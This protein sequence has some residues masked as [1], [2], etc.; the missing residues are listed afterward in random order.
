MRGR[1]LFDALLTAL[2]VFEMLYQITGNAL[3]EIVGAAFLACI[4]AHIAFAF[5]WLKNSVRSL[6][7]GKLAK[8]QRRLFAMAVLLGI[9]VVLLAFSSAV[10]S[11]ALWDAGIDLTALNPGNIWY[12]IHTV[13]SYALSILVV[14]HLVMHWAT[15]ADVLKVRYDP[16][17]REAI[18]SV[19]NGAVMVGGAALGIVGIMRAGFQASDFSVNEEGE[20][21]TG[22][23]QQGYREVNAETGE[24]MTESS[25]T[26]EAI[27]GE[28]GESLEVEE[29]ADDGKPTICPI[30]PRRCKLSAPRCERPYE[31]GLIS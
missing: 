23:V 19:L 6:A 15:I 30:C 5:K 24:Y 17:R 28:N 27:T 14:G 10:I 16:S 29:S 18:S 31:A 12:P 22:T 26:V 2:L 13:A 3:H 25:F 7:A 11:Q 4:V 8:K 9:D 21:E 1:I 20:K